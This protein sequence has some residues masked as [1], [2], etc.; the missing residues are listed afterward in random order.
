M[1]THTAIVLSL[2]GISLHLVVCGLDVGKAGLVV[3]PK[4]SH[5]LRETALLHSTTDIKS[6]LARL[7]SSEDKLTDKSPRLQRLLP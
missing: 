6:E 7:E 3:L 2:Q 1:Q 5:V 4:P